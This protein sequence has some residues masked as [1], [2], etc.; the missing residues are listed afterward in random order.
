VSALAPG[1]AAAKE[2]ALRRLERLRSAHDKFEPWSMNAKVLKHQI[3]EASTLLSEIE[4][5][6]RA[7]Q[8]EEVST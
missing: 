2:I 8:L 7:N 4:K 5:A 3:A 1:L 6:E